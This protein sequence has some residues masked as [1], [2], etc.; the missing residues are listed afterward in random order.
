LRAKIDNQPF[1]YE[2]PVK[3]EIVYK[4]QHMVAEMEKGVLEGSLWLQKKWKESGI[5]EKING[6]IYKDH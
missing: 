3:T 1:N 2:T 6:M 5:K 4:T